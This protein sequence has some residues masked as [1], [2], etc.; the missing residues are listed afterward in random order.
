M[1]N[2][3]TKCSNH[4]NP[5]EWK[6]KCISLHELN[7]CVCLAVYCKWNNEFAKKN[8]YYLKL[9][10]LSRLQ[11][12]RAHSKPKF[13]RFVFFEF[14]CT[15]KKQ[16]I[17]W[18]SSVELTKCSMLHAHRQK[19]W[20]PSEKKIYRTCECD[21]RSQ[22]QNENEKSQPISFIALPSDPQTRS[23]WL[24]PHVIRMWYMHNIFIFC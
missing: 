15:Q 12:V 1:L 9:S 21:H 20:K 14:K 5:N 7:V 17:Q 22:I 19:N 2:E 3:W 13:E 4:A 10:L 24:T 11:Y 8:R 18:K 16:S 6:E 23:L